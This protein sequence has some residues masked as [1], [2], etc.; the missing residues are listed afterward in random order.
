MLRKNKPTKGFEV[1]PVKTKEPYFGKSVE[2]AIIAYNNSTNPIE[3]NRLYNAKINRAFTKL[4]EV[5]INKYKFY[6]I[7]DKIKDTQNEVIVFLLEK[8]NKYSQDKGKAY[9]Y[10]TIVARNFLIINNT[11]AYKNK[12]AKADISVLDEHY[13]PEEATTSER[14]EFMDK[15]LLYVEYNM[16]RLFPKEQDY[17]IADAVVT[18]IKRKEHLP[19]INKKAVYVYLREM[20]DKNALQITKV[21]TIY[22]NVYKKLYTIYL[23]TDE[24]DMNNIPNTKTEK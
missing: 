2:E 16:H 17:L 22:R 20:T 5:L 21:L 7:N 11:T 23:D 8:L 14:I 6:Y 1:K 3:K 12:V 10:F 24:L 19:I 15:F 18:L 13:E 9:S 4:S